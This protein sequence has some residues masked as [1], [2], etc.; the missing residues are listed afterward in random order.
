M[1][2]KVKKP[3]PLIDKYDKFSVIAGLC[4]VP[5]KSSCVEV[6]GTTISIS[7]DKFH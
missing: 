4:R 3:V 7:K 5:G 2:R 1:V 6:Q